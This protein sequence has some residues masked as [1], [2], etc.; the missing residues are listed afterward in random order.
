MVGQQA[1]PFLKARRRAVENSRLGQWRGGGGVAASLFFQLLVNRLSKFITVRSSSASQDVSPTRSRP[2]PA[3]AAEQPM[4]LQAAQQFLA[5]PPA[6]SDGQD[7][8]N[9][10]GVRRIVA[11]AVTVADGKGIQFAAEQDG[12]GGRA[13]PTA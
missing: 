4:P 5:T 9:L 13:G 6:R 1:L 12:I 10:V 3:P 2:S 11:K 7:D 8:G